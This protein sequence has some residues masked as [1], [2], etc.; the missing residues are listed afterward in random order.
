MA[1]ICVLCSVSIEHRR[2]DAEVCGKACQ[3]KRDTIKR[4]ESG[5][6]RKVNMN[7]DKYAA[8]QSRAKRW[9]QQYKTW[10][11]VTCDAEVTVG[12]VY[13]SGY[14]C[15]RT[16]QLSYWNKGIEASKG[17]AIELKPKTVATV[18]INV[19]KGQWWTAGNCHVCKKLFV[20]PHLEKTCSP[21]C[22]QIK[23]RLTS[24]W[25]DTPTR[26]KIYERDGWNCQLCGENVDQNLEWLQYEWQPDYPTLD[27]IMP[28]SRGGSN[29]DDNLRLAHMGCNSLRGANPLGTSEG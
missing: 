21:R 5:R 9:R 27:H 18:K 14:W 17:R 6:L 16:C 2:I 11:C 7:A 13:K 25:I 12:N 26:L 23:N 22:R 1:R 10:A 28:R 15:S 20:S 29:D 19:L 24:K 4:R 3:V 8:K